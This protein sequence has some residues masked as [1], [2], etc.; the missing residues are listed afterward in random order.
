MSKIS[1]KEIII[2]GGGPAGISTWLHLNKIAPDLALKTVLIEKEKYPRDKLCGGAIVNIGQEVL[3]NLKANTDYPTV[4]INDTEYRYG[5]EVL[6]YK[7]K[8]FLKITNR[9][10]FDYSL[11][12]T[13][14]ERGLNIKQNEEF[15]SCFKKNNDIIVRTSRGNY[16]TKILIGADGAN[17]R[18]RNNMKNVKKPRL[19]PAIEVFSPVKNEID[20]EFATNK[21]TIDFSPLEEGLQGY[22]WHFPC[23]INNQPFMNHGICDIHMNPNKK[24]ADTKKI[25]KQELKK[26]KIDCKP[27]DWKG[28][29]VPWYDS[30]TKLSEENIILVGDAAGI[31]PLIGGGIHLSLLYGDAAANTILNAYNTNDYSFE[32]YED[33]IKSHFVGKYIKKFT[34]VANEIYNNDLNALDGIRKILPK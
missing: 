3:K 26:R 7:E 10:D 27:T 2:I 4:S 13:A 21:A 17:S 28:H 14:M 5:D 32:N 18:I 11:A 31:E 22:I 16:K 23:K 25:F 29:P 19:A 6:N 9:Y 30:Y 20:I 15:S 34:Y 1:K 24:R 33:K 12:K 8:N